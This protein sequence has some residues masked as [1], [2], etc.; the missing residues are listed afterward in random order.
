LDRQNTDKLKTLFANLP[1]ENVAFVMKCLCLPDFESRS[2]TVV[3][4]VRLSRN[5]PAIRWE[6]RVHEQIL[7]TIRRLGASVR[8]SDVVIHHLGYQNPALR[9]RKLERDLRLLALENEENPDHPFV[10]FNLGSIHHEL[11]RLTEALPLLQ[12]SLELSAPTDSIVRKLYALIAQCQRQM[13]RANEA[14]RTCLQ[15]RRYFPNDL[16]ILFRESVAR[17]ELGDLAGSEQ[18]LLQILGAREEDHFASVNANLRQFARHNLAVLCRDQGRV[19]D[20]EAHWRA[21]VAEEPDFADAWFGL[22]E[23]SLQGGRWSDLEATLSR[24]ESRAEYSRASALLRVRL[25]LGQ[26][27]FAKARQ[28]LE[29]M[30]RNDMRAVAPRIILSHVLLQDGRNPAAAEKVLREIL[31][32]EPSNQEARHNLDVLLREREKQA[33]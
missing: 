23:L 1:Q 33:P 6:H 27:E 15:G 3:D 9:R 30:I 20:A 5:H 31:A 22:A 8:W 19:A 10:L 18:C 25:Y 26:R 29:V 11:G 24:V 14:V 2:S 12:R 7:R 16:E 17:Q 13:G 4:H 21:I 32:L 28:F